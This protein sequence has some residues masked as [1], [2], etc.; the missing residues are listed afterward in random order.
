MEQSGCGQKQIRGGGGGGVD[1]IQSEVDQKIHVYRR[2]YL[3]AV[4]SSSSSQGSF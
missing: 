1:S 3:F 4:A 2:H